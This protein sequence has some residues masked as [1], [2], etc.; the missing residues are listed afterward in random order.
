MGEPEAVDQ[1][2]VVD[3]GSAVDEGRGAA[4]VTQGAE[5][6]PE[7]AAEVFGSRLA[8]ADEYV[9]ILTEEGVLR[10]LIGPSE[11]GRLWTRHILNSAV[12][13]EAIGSDLRVIDI[14][15][16]AGFPGIPLAIARPD[17]T[18]VLVDPLLRRTVFLEEVVQ[19]LSLDNVT[20]IRGRAEEKSVIEQSG[21]ADVVTSRAVAPLDRLARWSAPL[22]RPGGS[23]VALKGRTAIQEIAEHGAAV[24]RLGITDL[25]VREVGA[26]LL[27]PST[28]II[29]SR[30]ETAEDRRAAKRAERRQ[31]RKS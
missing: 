13:G 16:G 28:V 29:G 6:R 22:I 8:L 31:K 7:V 27:E 30:I 12:V 1:G 5:A 17:L 4:E 2:R 21:G 3:E 10:G 20:V 19:R 24:E 23:L 9:Q 26:M 11:P 14:G 15:S 18:V 25:R